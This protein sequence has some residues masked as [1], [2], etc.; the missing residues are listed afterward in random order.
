MPSV[1]RRRCL[2]LINS[3]SAL[4]ILLTPGQ[5]L[6]LCLQALDSRL[7]RDQHIIQGLN[8]IVLKSQT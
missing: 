4:H 2:I 3:N 8:R 1:M 6:Q 5:H 7:L